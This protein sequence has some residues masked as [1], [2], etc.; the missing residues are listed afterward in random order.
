MFYTAALRDF[1]HSPGKNEIDRLMSN[2]VT[3]LVCLTYR[4]MNF[5]WSE[6]AKIS[7]SCR[8][9]HSWTVC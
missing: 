6:N 8:V 2:T 4:E 7:N 1:V 5:F 3:L 9:G